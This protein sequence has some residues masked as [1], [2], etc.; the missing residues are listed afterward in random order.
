M[1][2]ERKLSRDGEIR[3][4]ILKVGLGYTA[5]IL[6]GGLVAACG[7]GG[8]DDPVPPLSN[9]HP[10]MFER[11][12]DSAADITPGD[13]VE[14]FKRYSSRISNTG[15]VA[16]MNTI[17]NTLNGTPVSAFKTGANKLTLIVED[18]AV[19]RVNWNQDGTNDY[20]GE[21]TDKNQVAIATQ[22]L[23][24]LHDYATKDQSFFDVE[25]NAV[26]D[27]YIN[28]NLGGKINAVRYNKTVALLGVG[29]VSFDY[30]IRE[31]ANFKIVILDTAISPISKSPGG[32]L[33]KL[34]QFVAAHPDGKVGTQ[35]V[36]VYS[37]NPNVLNALGPIAKD[38][39]LYNVDYGIRN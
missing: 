12:F 33:D 10:T 30:E 15:G 3:R 9:P 21:I 17:L 11:V 37:S 24:D 38:I 29:N 4:G 14:Y 26:V 28:A 39:T 8:G 13:I 5:G 34:K 23:Q 27:A 32:D 22:T 6:L 1:S 20:G 31:G 18:A 7:G 16:D 2:I 35:E 36:Q 25:V 19:G